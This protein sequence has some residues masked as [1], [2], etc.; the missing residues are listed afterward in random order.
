MGTLCLAAKPCRGT[1]LRSF[2]CQTGSIKVSSDLRT[3]EEP[4]W[5]LDWP[6]SSLWRDPCLESGK[7]QFWR[8]Y[9]IAIFGGDLEGV[10]DHCQERE[11]ADHD[12]Q[13]DHAGFANVLQGCLISL[14]AA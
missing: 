1:A 5:D 3:Q 9:A 7:P 2:R 14:I 10:K 8:G 12:G 11:V 4:V 13:L 6:D